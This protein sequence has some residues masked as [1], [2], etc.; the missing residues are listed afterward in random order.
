MNRITRTDFS[1]ALSEML[2]P[3]LLITGAENKPPQP[4]SL[5]LVDR[6]RHVECTRDKRERQQQDVGFSSRPFTLCNL[7]VRPV[8]D[9]AVYERSNGNF[10]CGLR[11]D[12]VESCHTV[13]TGLC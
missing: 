9:R 7:P 6:I 5:R 10:F 4:L 1:T 13:G 12:R 11:R 3:D 2:E 8:K